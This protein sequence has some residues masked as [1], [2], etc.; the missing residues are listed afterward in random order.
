MKPHF[1]LLLLL[2]VFATCQS[3]DSK[4]DADTQQA[5]PAEESA[6]ADGPKQG[7]MKGNIYIEKLTDYSPQFIAGIQNAAKDIVV[8]SMLGDRLVTKGGDTLRFPT[9]PPIGNELVF[10]GGEAGEEVELR[11]ERVNQSTIR[12]GMV[13]HLAEGGTYEM[14][15]LADLSPLFFLGA[16]SDED[17]QT[18]L[19]YLAS[20]F[21]DPASE[22]SNSIR[23]G[24]AEESGPYLA[25]LVMDC[26]DL[27]MSLEESP[28]L[29]TQ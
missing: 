17:E 7:V 2:F 19:S 22:C 1:F 5:T 24:Q 3:S 29:R 28:T 10:T 13:I 6:N 4:A 8:V 20:E 21:S 23:I 11:V 16:E 15:S 27:P 25:K 18:G 14:K 9:T 26:F 12:Y